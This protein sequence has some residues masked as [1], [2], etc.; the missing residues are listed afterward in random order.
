M[1][2]QNENSDGNYFPFSY[3]SGEFQTPEELDIE[4]GIKKAVVD[5][6]IY[7]ECTKYQKLNNSYLLSTI[8]LNSL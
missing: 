2:R 5:F 8:N 1:I 7:F 4:Y 6:P 3:T